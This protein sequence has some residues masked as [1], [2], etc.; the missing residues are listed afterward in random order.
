MHHSISTNE[1]RNELNEKGHLLSNII[2]VKHKA[3]KEPLPPLFVDLE[4]RDHNEDIYKLQFLQHCKIKSRTLKAQKSD[5]TMHTVPNLW[6]HKKLLL[7][8]LQLCQ[9]QGATQYLK[10]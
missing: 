7:K 4:P 9:M 3:T 2:N 5:C 1:P 10:L 8:A 6:P